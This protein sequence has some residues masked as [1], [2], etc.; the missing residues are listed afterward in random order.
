MSNVLKSKSLLGI[1]IVAVIVAG[2]LFA[3]ALTASAA[4]MHTGTLK[5]GST[6]SQVMS[7]QQTLNANGYLVSSVGAG[8]PGLESSYFG[9]KTKAAVMAFQ[10][11]RGP[12]ADGVVGPLTGAVLAGLTGAPVSGLPAGCTSTAGF[13]PTTGASCSSGTSLPAGCMP[14]YLFSSTTGASCSGGSTPSTSGLLTGGAGSVDSY[15]LASGLSNEE[16]GEDADDVKVVG[17]EIENS[18]DSDI[19]LTA[20]RLVF[21]EGT[22]ASDF[23]NYAKDVSIWLGSTEV[24]REDGDEFNDNNAWTKTVSLDSSAVIDAGDTEILYVAIS[25]VSNLDTND[26]ADTWTV[27]MTS[28]RFVDA[29]GTSIYED[30]TVAATPFSFESFATSADTELK[31]TESGSAN[32]L[33]NDAHLVNV[34]AT[35]TTDNVPILAFDIEIEGTSDVTIDDLPITL[36]STEAAGAD[37]DEPGDI[38]TTLRLFADGVEIGSESV[39]GAAAGG[40]DTQVVLFDDLDYVIDAGD[41]VNFVVKGKF[42]ALSGALD[43]ADT[44][45]AAFGETETDLATFDAEDE[46]GENLADADKTGTAN[47]TASEIRDV[48]FTLELVSATAVKTAGEVTV[49]PSDTGLFTITFDVTAWD[50][51]IYIDASAPLEAGGSGEADLTVTGAGTVVATLTSPSGATASANTTFLVAEDDTERFSINVDIRD[52]ATDMVDGFFDVALADLVYAL[53]AIDGNLGYTFNLVDFK[54]PQI[55]LNDG[56]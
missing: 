24:A 12:A 25:G 18:N 36:T 56:E 42:V 26:A 52:G 3:F 21:D 38:I 48:G 44:I 49:Q 43:V 41:T 9:A 11:A 50:G 31:I 6:G 10:A 19:R 39:D 7:L 53:T 16:V 5:M 2:A 30:P 23:D 14:G 40:A 20:L 22:A 32:E 51:D 17:L 13:S 34:H 8:S 27:D 33:V 1:T 45:A 4:Y 35:N 28:L 15:D 55:F 46:T 29:T 47:S 37:F 54:T